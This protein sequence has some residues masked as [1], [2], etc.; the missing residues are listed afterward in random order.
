M[1]TARSIRSD[2]APYRRRT[3]S[4]LDGSFS[5]ARMAFVSSRNGSSSRCSYDISSY[6]RLLWGC[7]VKKSVSRTPASS[8]RA[9]GAADSASSIASSRE[10][11]RFFIIA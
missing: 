1:V 11:I 6:W 9:A 4:S 2:R 5:R 8:A 3:A 10:I 7:L